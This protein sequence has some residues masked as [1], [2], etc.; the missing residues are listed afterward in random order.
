M[1]HKKDVARTKPIGRRAVLAGAA[2]TTVAAAV[3]LRFAH[4]Q[5]Q[6]LKIGTLYPRSG[7]QAQ[8]GIDCMRGIECT[9]EVLKARGYPEFEI[10]AGDTETNPAVA[11][12]QCERLI[13]QGANI[14]TGCFDSGQTLAAAQVCEQKGIPFAVAIAAAPALTEQGYKTVFRNFPTGPMIVTDSLNLQKELFTVTGH[15]PKTMVMLHTNDTYGTNTKDA[16]IK[17]FP[18]FNMPYKTLETIAY[19]PAA[20]DL[21][22]EVRK[23]KATGAELL[24]VISRVNDAMLITQEMVKQRWVPMGIVSAGPGWYE[25]VYMSTLGKLSDDV[26]TTAPW[27]D[28]NKP[29]SKALEAVFKAKFP[30]RELNTNH[31][32]SFEGVLIAA[33]AFKRAG[34]TES[35]K[36]IDALRRTDIKENITTGPGISFNERGQNPNV[37]NSAFQNRGGKNLVVLPLNA[38]VTK[39]NWPMRAWNARD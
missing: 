1:T 11:R 5:G 2:A 32:Y 37:K 30:D 8:I 16:F 25:S 9:T 29:L 26:V 24:M 38:A 12:A 34:S 13:E 23:A 39:P 4:A 27:H 28:P 14:I 31:T 20:R 15:T 10:L 35:S 17:L 33:D 21:S 22:A 36:L 3:P 18:G 19:D 6:K 7:I